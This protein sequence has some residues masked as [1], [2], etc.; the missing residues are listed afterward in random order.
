[1]IIHLQKVRFR[2][3]F[4]VTEGLLLPVEETYTPE[5]SFLFGLFCV[6]LLCI[7]IHITILRLLLRKKEVGPEKE[8]GFCLFLFFFLLAAVGKL[9]KPLFVLQKTRK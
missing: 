8:L 4:G 6:I 2:V 7:A 9:E 1:M 5:M 3:S